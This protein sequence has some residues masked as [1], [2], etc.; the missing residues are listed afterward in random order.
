LALDGLFR[1][2]IVRISIIVLLFAGSVASAGFEP[3]RFGHLPDGTKY[4]DNKIIVACDYSAPELRT[5]HSSSG[6]ASTGIESIDRICCNLAVTRVDPFYRGHL[7]KPAL[8]GTVSR[9]YIFTVAD[10][11]DIMDVIPVLT[12]DPQIRL[13]EPY[14]VPEL[15]YEPNDPYLDQQW[16]FAH[17]HTLEAW[18]TVRGDTT[19][20]S[21]IAVVDTG[22]D[23]EHED[24]GPNL[25]VNAVED[26]NGDGY[27]DEGDINNI[28]DDDN[29]F[30]DDVIG[31]DFGEDDN[32][33]AEE[34]MIHG[35]AV[36]GCA[37]EATDNG[38][39]GAGMGF[40][41]RLMALKA[42][43]G[44]GSWNG[45]QCLIYAA[46]NGADIINC[47]WGLLNQSQSEQDIINAVWEE[48]VLII[49]SAGGNSNDTPIYPAAYDHVMAVTATDQT[50]HKAYFAGFGSWVDISAP[51]VEVY[52]IY[53]DD[54]S[55][56][57]GTSFS[58]AM[59]SGLAGLVATW[60]PDLVNDEIQEIIE[61]SADP[62]D[63][64]NPGFEGMLG[65]G[66]INSLACV[67][68]AVEYEDTSP[69]LFGFDP[70]YPNP[71]NSSTVLSFHLGEALPV[72]IS[73]YSI[74]G[75]RV[76][77]L[78][79]GMLEA[80]E[81]RIPWDADDLPSGVYFARIEANEQSR[82]LKMLLV[83]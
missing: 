15:H 7:R 79:Q 30:V 5:G 65:A 17:T 77:T 3:D 1:E 24:L 50:D 52:A 43:G 35:S 37:S 34:V 28:D 11:T 47:S 82:C 26:L 29:G 71:F 58:A 49:A 18:D 27:L 2:D 64:L 9:L 54:Y 31:W 59:V 22:I 14:T 38:I 12:G 10:G 66:R 6:Y 75:Q 40:S 20:H 21:V 74:M 51:G 41:A 44:D 45:Y 16:Y 67:R 63:H 60:Y 53:G 70:N 72:E 61:S 13:A 78:H 68:T 69:T 4:M 25:W 80:G 8:A 19:R 83:R 23:Q 39:L 56:V 36:A 32:D 46:D 33:P 81:H 62:I 42:N 55:I 48:G 76:A 57:S 73:I